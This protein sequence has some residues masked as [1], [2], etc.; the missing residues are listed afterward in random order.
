[1]LLK[2]Y[3]TLLWKTLYSLWVFSQMRRI[4]LLFPEEKIPF[5]DLINLNHFSLTFSE[6][7]LQNDA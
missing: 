1:M 7:F 6:V 2:Y 3:K 4:F 5:P